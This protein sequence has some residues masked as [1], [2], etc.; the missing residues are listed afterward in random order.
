MLILISDSG[1]VIEDGGVLGQDGDAALA[2]QFVGVHH[3]LDVVS[4]ARKMPLWF[5][6]ASTSVVLPWSTCAM[7]AMLRKKCS[8]HFFHRAL[9][10]RIPSL[11]VDSGPSESV[12]AKK[13]RSIGC[14]ARG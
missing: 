13:T 12:L 4:L 5:S 6:M 3:A 8:F 10:A 1:W 2:L 14:R 9:A 7:M 11:V